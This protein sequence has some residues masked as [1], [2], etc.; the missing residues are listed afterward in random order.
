MPRLIEW[1]QIGDGT[2]FNAMATAGDTPEVVWRDHDRVRDQ[3]RLAVD[4]ALQTVLSYAELH[5]DN[6]P[7]ILILGDHQAAGFVGAGRRARCADPCH[8]T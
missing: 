7:L 6:P 1:D 4:Y 8:R 3:Y 2:E 5:A